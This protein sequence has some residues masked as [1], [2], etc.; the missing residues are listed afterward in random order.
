[1]P[2]KYRSK[3]RGVNLVATL[4]FVVNRQFGNIKKTSK[5]IYDVFREQ[6]IETI[7]MLKLLFIL[8]FRTKFRDIRLKF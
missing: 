6:N 3:S 1:M 4:S 7:E 8:N 2:I 5:V